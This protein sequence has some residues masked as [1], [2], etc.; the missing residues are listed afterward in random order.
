MSGTFLLILR[1]VMAVALYAFLGWAVYTIWWNMKRQT[2][3]ISSQSSPKLKVFSEFGGDSR[4]Y[5][6]TGPEIMIGRD[7][8]CDVILDANTVSAE[9]ARIS[10]HHQNWWVEDLESRNGTLLNLAKVTTPSVLVSGDELQLGEVMLKMWIQD[11]AE[12][13]NHTLSE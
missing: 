8:T 9:H 10:Y 6:F 13:P 3:W 7:Q 5:E 11:A 4:E 1:L 2:E 12:N